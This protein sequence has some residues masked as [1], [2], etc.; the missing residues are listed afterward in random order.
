MQTASK[1]KKT[2][3]A[4]YLLYMWQIEDLIRALQFDMSLIEKNLIQSAT[5]EDRKAMYDWYESLVEMMLLENKRD[6]GHLQININVLDDLNEFHLLLLKSGKAPEYNGKFMY[7]LPMINQLRMKSE[8]GLSDIELCL[9]F[10]YLFMLMK[11]KR[12]V[13]SKETS[14]IQVEFAKL[15]VLLTKNYHAFQNG[16]LDLE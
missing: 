11:M 7:V 1:L 9:N 2:N 16:Q 12:T 6:Q 10:Q 14:D 13:I 8:T 3:I 5:P 4:E 15:L